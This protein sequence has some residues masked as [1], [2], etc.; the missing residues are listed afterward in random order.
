MKAPL[1]GVPVADRLHAD[2]FS[3]GRR[4]TGSAQQAGQLHEHTELVLG[5]ALQRGIRSAGAKADPVCIP[6]EVGKYLGLA[7]FLAAESLGLQ[8]ACGEPARTGPRLER[9]SEFADQQLRLV[10]FCL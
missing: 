2:G 4:C 8:P 5:T 1:L 3:R 7:Y 10:I 6:L 9:E